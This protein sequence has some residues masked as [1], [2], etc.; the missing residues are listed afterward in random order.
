[1]I[2]NE[3][4][5]SLLGDFLPQMRDTGRFRGGKSRKDYTVRSGI[6]DPESIQRHLQE[7]LGE[8]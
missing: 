2:V 6:R 3:E 7:M 8:Q 1:M 4:L 5:V